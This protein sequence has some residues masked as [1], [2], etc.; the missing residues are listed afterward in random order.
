MTIN[1][2]NAG[3]GV[4]LRNDN[5]TFAGTLIVNGIASTTVGAGSG[6]GVLGNTTG[7]QNADIQLNGTMELRDHGSGLS[8]ANDFY[9][10]SGA[11]STF[12]MGALSGSGVMVGNESNAGATTTVTL[13][14]TNND[15]TFSGVIADGVNNVTSIFKVGTGTQIFSGPSTYTGGTAIQ[16]GTLEIRHN[17]ALG[18][19]E[20]RLVWTGVA[21]ARTLAFGADGLDLSENV[22]IGNQ[23]SS[24]TIRLDSGGAGHTGTLSGQLDMR[25]SA[26]GE[27]VMDVGVSDTLTVS[28]NIVTLSPPGGAGAGITKVGDGTLVLSGINS[29]FGDTIINAGTLLANNV[30]GSATSTGAVTVNANATLGGTGSIGGATTVNS[31]GIIAPGNST[32]TLTFSNGLT[33]SGGSNLTMELETPTTDQDQIV[34][35]GGTFSSAATV[36][37]TVQGT[38]ALGSYLLID[39]SGATTWTTDISHYSVVM[40]GGYFGVLRNDAVNKQLWLDVSGLTTVFTFK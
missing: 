39:G 36:T 24:S 35:S 26:P 8:W 13:G 17:D 15:G 33:L 22:R 37:L 11:A 28:G 25:R 3:T 23:S 12:Q 6:I 19:G 34:V 21:S 32:G 18:T 10:G 27:F 2:T 9:F 14:N 38:P 40:P 31:A 1:A 20:I 5:S 16:E 29:Y 7:L 30:S 4:N